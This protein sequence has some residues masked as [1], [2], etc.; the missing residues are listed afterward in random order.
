LGY[1]AAT[2]LAGRQAQEPILLDASAL[3]ARLGSFLRDWQ[4]LLRENVAEARTLL[5]LALTT[6]NWHQGPIPAR[7]VITSN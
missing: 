6:K 5:D 4:G 2:E 7:A 1:L 3:R